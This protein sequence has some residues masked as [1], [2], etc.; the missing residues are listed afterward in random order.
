MS[1]LKGAENYVQL[2]LVFYLCDSTDD[3]NAGFCCFFFFFCL[4][5][6]FPGCLCDEMLHR[7]KIFLFVYY[8]KKKK[9]EQLCKCNS[10]VL[11]TRKTLCP[12][13]QGRESR[14]LIY[15]FITMCH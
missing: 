11:V 10:G 12:I 3:V 9:N 14:K 13:K 5:L 1:A 15:R 7:N 8:F 2:F 6:L 4:F